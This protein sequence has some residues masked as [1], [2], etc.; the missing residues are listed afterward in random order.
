MTMRRDER[1]FEEAEGESEIAAIE[2]Q[3][4][5]KWADLGGPKLEIDTIRRR[6][7]F[8]ILDHCVRPLPKGARLLD[9]G[10]GMGYWTVHYS[11][12]GYPT[13]GLDVSKATIAKLRQLFPDV[14]F[15]SA[16][17]RAT[18]LPDASFDLYFSWGTFEHF[19][20][21]FGPVVSEAYRLLKP[22]GRLLIST[23]FDNLRLA[24]RSALLEEF[25]L[26]PTGGRTRFYQWR[27]TRGEMARILTQHGFSVESIHM[28]H[29]RQGLM[30]WL[31]NSVG[32]S[33]Q[34]TFNRGTA[35][36][37]SPFLPAVVFAHMI[38]GV[39]TKP[40]A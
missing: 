21:G 6:E 20:E 23:P 38:L 10:C 17:I 26:L 24:F 7:E 19:E 2:A 37:L 30:R 29:K 15:A 8:R 4:T 31:Q 1:P 25:R 39:A 5:K 28:I 40:S 14:E 35:F 36:V 16:D 32:L 27:L 33:V 18:G 11:R 34:S 22:G 13:L 9:G 3:W 12:A